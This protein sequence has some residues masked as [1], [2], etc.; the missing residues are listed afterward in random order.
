LSLLLLKAMKG[1]CSSV[2]IAIIEAA[3]ATITEISGARHREAA[4]RLAVAI[5]LLTLQLNVAMDCLAAL[6]M[7]RLTNNQKIESNS[8]LP[9]TQISVNNTKVPK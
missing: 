9:S 8:A 1:V 4:Q 2:V 6:A 5:Q 3:V 7:T